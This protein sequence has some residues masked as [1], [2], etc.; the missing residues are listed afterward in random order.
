M[1]I[2]VRSLPS[3]GAMLTRP[4]GS[5]KLT[6]RVLDIAVGKPARCGTVV[7]VSA[8]KLLRLGVS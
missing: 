6:R 5:L 7:V 2:F 3:K 8:R 4:A 1:D